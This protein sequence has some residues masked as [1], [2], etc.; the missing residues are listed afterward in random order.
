MPAVIIDD[1]GC[2]SSTRISSFARNKS[3]QKSFNGSF[4]FPR[5]E[6][7]TAE[8][9][10]V[11][12][13]TSINNSTIIKSPIRP[14]KTL[15]IASLNTRTLIARWRQMELVG[16]CVRQSIGILAI[17]EH[18]IYFEV[19]AN[20]DLVRRKCLGG[21]WWFIYSSALKNGSGGVGFILNNDIYRSILSIHSVSDRILKV[22]IGGGDAFKS[23]F[24]S[25]Y[26]PT[27]AA[28]ESAITT[29]YSSLSDCLCQIPLST[30]LFVLGDF[31]AMILQ[32]RLYPNCAN[33]VVNRNEY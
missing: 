12:L 20:D 7:P 19:N 15:N 14:R 16:Y 1:W 3:K 33:K 5:N 4:N 31:N 10:L 25:I 8:S 23:C 21:G 26:S 27:A 22:S 9:G 30:M 17:Q 24:V 11:K 28:D 6:N 32:T 29:F 18:R 13:N 2:R